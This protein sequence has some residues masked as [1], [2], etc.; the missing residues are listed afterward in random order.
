MPGV[1]IK[2]KIVT[3]ERIVFEEEI[4][5]I[6]LPVTDGQVTILPD[7]TSYIASLKAGEIYFKKE[8]QEINMATSGGFAEFDKNT[9]VILADSA[10]RAEEIDIKAAK[11]AKERAEELMKTRESMDDEEYARVAAA[12]E[13]ESAR[14]KVARKH[15][16]K[17]GI[18]IE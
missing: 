13:R 12:I 8:G 4:D 15:Y 10:D 5:Q 17:R 1:K 3:P 7:H 16:T 9:L 11:E 2:F 14:I 18:N 6:T